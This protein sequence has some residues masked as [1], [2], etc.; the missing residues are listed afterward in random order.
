[1]LETYQLSKFATVVSFSLSSSA[2]SP[3][4]ALLAPGGRGQLQIDKQ[5]TDD[6]VVSSVSDTGIF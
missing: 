4:A 6:N 1:M 2:S 3:G 5:L